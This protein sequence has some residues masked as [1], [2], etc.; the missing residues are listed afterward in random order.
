MNFEIIEDISWADC[1]LR[2]YGNSLEEILQNS[3]MALLSQ[4]VENPADIESRL[5]LSI[6][7]ENE[8][9]DLLL[10][11]T[12]E[13]LIFI[14]DS[15]HILLVPLGTHIKKT[16][17]EYKLVMHL[18]GEEIDRARHCLKTDIKGITMHKLEI[19]CAEN[20]TWQATFVL[21]V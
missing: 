20:G 6:Q 7:I 18:A 14:K 17:Q 11:N 12:I 3:A 5:N 10:Y 15:R 19:T 16:G 2:I 4:M 21:D 13:E 8:K 9:P 1:A